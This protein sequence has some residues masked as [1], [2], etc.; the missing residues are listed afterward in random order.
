MSNVKVERTIFPGGEVNVRLK[1]MGKTLEVVIRNSEDLIALG[2]TKYALGNEEVHLVL[3][4]F[5]YARQDRI[6]NVGEANSMQFM[7]DYLNM[8]D[9]ASVLVWDIHNEDTLSLI[10]NVKHASASD[11]WFNM[12][13]DYGFDALCSPD[14]GAAKKL[15]KYGAKVDVVGR[16]VRDPLTGEITGTEIKGSVYDKHV[17]I[18]DDICDGGRTFIELAKVLRKEGASK[19]TLVVT[20]G[21]FSKGMDVFEDIDHVYCTNSLYPETTCTVVQVK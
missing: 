4:Y 1:E 7:A 18:L 12:L 17:V 11:L 20:H 10:N 5:P 14:A 15:K 16:K 6:C 9:F 13:E 8:L 2:L 3:K 19:I 21:I